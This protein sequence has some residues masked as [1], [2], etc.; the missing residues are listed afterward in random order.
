MLKASI[1]IRLMSISSSKCW[2]FSCVCY[3]CGWMHF[4]NQMVFGKV[5]LGSVQSHNEW[6]QCGLIHVLSISIR[7]QGKLQKWWV[8]EITSN[9]KI[10]LVNVGSL[11]ITVANFANLINQQYFHVLSPT[12]IASILQRTF[13]NAFLGMKKVYCMW[14]NQWYCH[15]IT[16]ISTLMVLKLGYYGQTL[17]IA[18]LLISTGATSIKRCC[19]TGI[20]ISMLKIRRSCDRLILNMRIAIPGKDGFVLRLGPGP[21]H[22]QYTNSHGRIYGSLSSMDR[23]INC[24]H[25][26]FVAKW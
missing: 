12:Q 26:V 4:V 22:H 24:R 6:W 7:T 21:L 2:C 15:F 20:G 1:N 16:I 11:Y 5:I 8:S 10:Q 18:W 13:W 19:L 9:Y 3:E 14:V 25:H 17:S 23:D